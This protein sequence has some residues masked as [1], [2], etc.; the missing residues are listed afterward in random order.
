MSVPSATGASALTALSPRGENRRGGS[1][2]DGSAK[3]ADLPP[4]ERDGE[5]AA[6]QSR[7]AR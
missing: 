1:A 7:Q 4:S 3:D 5:A 2:A 6:G